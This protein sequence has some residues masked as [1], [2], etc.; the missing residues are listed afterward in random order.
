MPALKLER[1]KCKE[2]INLNRA[3]QSKLIDLLLTGCEIIEMEGILFVV[4]SEATKEK[5]AC[6]DLRHFAYLCLV[7]RTFMNQNRALNKI[8][9]PDAGGTHAAESVVPLPDQ[10]A[11]PSELYADVSPPTPT[12][13]HSANFINQRR[14]VRHLAEAR[15]NT[16]SVQLVKLATEI[17]YYDPLMAEVLDEALDATE[18]AIAMMQDDR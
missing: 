18:A 17:R 10:W 16:L 5:N 3:S 6:C 11:Q 14:K 1:A 7:G 9:H 15:L 8:I 12:K 4:V 13:K 2:W